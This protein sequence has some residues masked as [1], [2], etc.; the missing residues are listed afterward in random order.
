[1]TRFT[2][3]LSRLVKLTKKVI[4]FTEPRVPERSDGRGAVIEK[5]VRRCALW[6]PAAPRCG[7]QFRRAA[8]TDY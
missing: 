4:A 1:M 5:I 7:G 6:Q 8:G 3:S 2:F